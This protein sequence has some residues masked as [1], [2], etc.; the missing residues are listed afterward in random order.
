[1]RTISS[2]RPRQVCGNL[3]VDPGLNQYG[4][5]NEKPNNPLSYM[6][7]N[8]KLGVTRGKF[9]TKTINGHSLP[10]P[11]TQL[12]SLQ[13]NNTGGSGNNPVPPNIQNLNSY[14]V[15]Q[16]QNVAQN[17]AV[18]TQARQ[19]LQ[20]RLRGSIAVS[21]NP[22]ALRKQ[23]LIHD[24][25]LKEK[26]IKKSKQKIQENI[27]RFDKTMK[28]VSRKTYLKYLKSSLKK[29]RENLQ[30]LTHQ[31]EDVVNRHKHRHKEKEKKLETPET[32]M[33]EAQREKRRNIHVPRGLGID[34][35]EKTADVG[36]LYELQQV[37]NVVTD[38]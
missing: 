12:K 16:N 5:A 21:Q 25:N 24:V 19:T 30:R 9:M 3:S 29:E 26:E 13:N 27:N 23:G 10:N 8:L 35:K 4:L 34:D 20:Q 33:Q 32:E 1:M 14:T 18:N 31:V 6:L 28:K 22:N 15:R 17:N 38:T 37:Q 11:V 7:A 36:R 2:R